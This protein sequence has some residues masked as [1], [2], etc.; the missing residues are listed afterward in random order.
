MKYYVSFFGS[1]FTEVSKSRYYS[2][3]RRKNFHETVSTVN[4]YIASRYLDL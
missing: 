4:G 2:L 1:R 3:R